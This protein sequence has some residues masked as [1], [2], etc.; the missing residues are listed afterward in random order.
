MKVAYV[1]SR[2]EGLEDATVRQD[3]RE[4][5]HNVKVCTSFVLYCKPFILI[6]YDLPLIKLIEVHNVHANIF[7]MFPY[8]ILER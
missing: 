8:D 5:E 2:K 1:K 3:S 6:T 7:I 4:M